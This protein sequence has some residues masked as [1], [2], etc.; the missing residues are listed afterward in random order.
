MAQ[1]CSDRI[2]NLFRLD[3]DQEDSWYL[4]APGNVHKDKPAIFGPQDINQIASHS[5]TGSPDAGMYTRNKLRGVWD[6]I[7]INAASRAAVKKS[8][9]NLIVYN[10]AQETTDSSQ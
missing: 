3:K 10:I 5:F 7:F 1:N 2:K 9:Q 6:S 8:S 4:L